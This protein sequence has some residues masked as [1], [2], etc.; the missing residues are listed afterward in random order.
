[1]NFVRY[2]RVYIGKGELPTHPLQTTIAKTKS[3]LFSQPASCPSSSS[4]ILQAGE[5]RRAKNQEQQY[6]MLLRFVS[7]V[8]ETIPRHSD[9]RK[10]DAEYLRLRAISTTLMEELEQLKFKIKLLDRE[11]LYLPTSAPGAVKFGPEIDSLKSI[12]QQQ[13]HNGVGNG[14]SGDTASALDG[15]GSP[16]WAAMIA[17][18]SDKV[19]TLTT[20]PSGALSPTSKLLEMP[21]VTPGL[22]LP[23]ASV[24]M[25]SKHALGGTL[26]QPVAH[27]PELSYV[28]TVEAA[29]GKPPPSYSE[30]LASLDINKPSPYS[31]QL[32]LGP[33]ELNVH[34]APYPTGPLPPGATCCPP[35]PPPPLDNTSSTISSASTATAVAAAPTPPTTGVAEVRKRQRIRDVHLSASLMK[36]FLRYADVNTRRGI[37]T[38]G[39]LAGALSPDDARFTITCLIVPKQEGTTDTVQAL[40]EEEIFEVQDSRALYPLGW[41]HTHPTQSCF[42]SSVDVHTHCG[43]QTMLDEAVAIVMAPSQERHQMGVF[44]LTT[45]GGLSLIQQCPLRGFHA[46]PPTNTG[47]PLYEECSNVYLNE[48]IGYEVID[49]RAK[50]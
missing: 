10:N 18:Q 47:Q 3:Q 25:L 26:P 40:A 29:T 2:V 36:E 37:E 17:S 24:E 1:M 44:R 34:T 42:L 30:L 8:L 35:P 45:P 32:Q 15:L 48:R 14:G 33:Q 31:G 46:H 9:Y 16:E 11:N 6:L 41:I 12:D 13:K 20:R 39:I 49:L 43:Y 28:D 4:L 22:A 5:Y 19:S 38:C 27:R 50:R 21:D 7:L 23:A